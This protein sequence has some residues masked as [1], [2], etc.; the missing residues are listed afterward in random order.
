M[1]LGQAHGLADLFTD[2]PTAKRLVLQ[3][4][5]RTYVSVEQLSLLWG[6]DKSLVSNWLRW[7]PG[8]VRRLGVHTKTCY[9][10]NVKTKA[11]ALCGPGLEPPVAPGR[12]FRGRRAAAR[13]HVRRRDG[14]RD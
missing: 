5:L 10:K 14:H 4:P 12:R 9:A 8:S 1:Y 6:S 7:N 3:V 13:R 11:I 2:D